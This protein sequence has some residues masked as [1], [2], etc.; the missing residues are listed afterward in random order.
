MRFLRTYLLKWG[1]GLA[2]ALGL[3][4]LAQPISRLLGNLVLS[5]QGIDPVGRGSPV[6]AIPVAVLLGL[7]VANTIGIGPRFTAGLQMAV[8]KVLRLGVILVG[9]KLSLFDV[10]KVGTLGVPV[11]LALVT[12]ALVAA[13]FIARQTG[14]GDRL[15]TLAAAST[16]ICGITATL[17][18]APGI[19]AEDREV[20]YTVAN[21]TLFGLLGMLFYPYIAHTLFAGEPGAAGLFLGTAIHDTSQVMG[22]ALSYKEVYGD[23]QAMQVATVA[24]LTRNSLLVVVVPVLVWLHARRAGIERK[25]LPLARLFPLFVVGFLA[26]S[27]VRTIGQLGLENGGRAFG[28]FEAPTWKEGVVFFGE[29]VATLALATALAA[30]G[31]TTRLAVLKGLGLRPFVVGLAAALVVS[32]ASLALAATFGP[33][34][35]TS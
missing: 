35:G 9:L 13:L 21:V 11:V 26:L 28:L 32:L 25:A 10:L 12:F 30:V 19:E 15:G 17:A 20:A 3:A 6:S 16:A 24:K 7:T 8:T 33:M 23:A 31:L 29:T 22:A 2:L 1:P 5:L 27:L 34:L 4:L 18:V 14:V